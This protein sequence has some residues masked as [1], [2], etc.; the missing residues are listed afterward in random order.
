[1]QQVRGHSRHGASSADRRA[2]CPGSVRLTDTLPAD[3]VNQKSIW[4][5]EGDDAHEL[6]AYAL[7]NK[8]RSADLASAMLR[9]EPNDE[10][11]DSV[12]VALDHVWGILD[13]YPA[14]EM[15]VEKTWEMPSTTAP[16]EVWGT[17]DIAIFVHELDLLHV[18]DFKHGA[19]VAVDI[20][21]N[22]QTL[23]YAASVNNELFNLAKEI[24]VTIVQPRC[25]HPEGF[26]RSRIVSKERLWAYIEEH[27]EIIRAS[28]APDA[29]LVPGTKQCQFCPAKVI[30]PALEAQALTVV[31]DTF[32]SVKDVTMANLPEP[33]SLPVDRIAF[34]LDAAPLLEEWL[35]AV[36]KVAYEHMK[37]G[38]V[39]PGRKLVEAQAKRK[40]HGE[41]AEIA[42]GLVELSGLPIDEWY[43]RELTTI[44]EAERR[45]KAVF[46]AKGAPS[47]AASKALAKFTLKQSSGNLTMVGL[48]DNRPAVNTAQVAFK[49]VNMLPPPPTGEQK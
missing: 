7:N 42:Q 46:R 16:G 11:I 21:N 20:E 17:A 3:I 35:E 44:T 47:D 45:L 14:V 15:W 28:Q 22:R 48:E 40:W 30:C 27:D 29:P 32:K 33:T 34:I 13:A 9:A 37:N 43:K 49:S 36:R 8:F 5:E 4:A 25:F 24:I 1:M 6:L 38:G 41:P 23:Q 31:K 10:E 19:G 12:Q 26:I 18:I 2:L 39:I